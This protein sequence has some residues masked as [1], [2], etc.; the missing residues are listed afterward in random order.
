MNLRGFAK[1]INH[2]RSSGVILIAALSLSA[3]CTFNSNDC[4][5]D[6]G[7]SITIDNDEFD[8]FQKELAQKIAQKVGQNNQFTI[9]PTLD[10]GVYPIGTLMPIGHTIEIQDICETRQP[11]F[12]PFGGL[13][14]TLDLTQGVAVAAGLAEALGP[15]ASADA[16]LN[17]KRKITLGLSDASI[18][19][20]SIADLQNLLKDKKCTAKIAGQRLIMVRGYIQ[21]KR[22]FTAHVDRNGSL[23]VGV[24]KIANFDASFDNGTQTLTLDDSS[25]FKFLQIT[26]EINVVPSQ[27][28]E[29]SL[30]VVSST[31][32]G[33]QPDIAGKIYIQ[34][35]ATDKSNRAKNLESVLKTSFDVANGIEKIP[36]A[37]MPRQTQVRYFNAKDA[38][39][40]KAV[41]ALVRQTNPD[42][43][44]RYVGLPAPTG[45]LEVW[46]TQN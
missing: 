28:G 29:N 17:A 32:Q 43:T 14:T 21:A 36:S 35:D 26:S 37:K 1:L 24:S 30:I 12:Y 31:Q 23:K 18:Q 27:N 16:T 4:K 25:P 7:A 6:R 19:Q 44:V 5:V 38:D 22:S 2:G 11:D 39:K 15:I 40:A 41:L 46:L 34:I 13:N 10:V 33:P 42:A 45:Q 3:C 8:P 9:T 20:L